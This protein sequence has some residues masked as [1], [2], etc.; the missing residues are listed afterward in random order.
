MSKILAIDAEVESGAEAVELQDAIRR[1]FERL[2]ALGTEIAG[3]QADIDRLKA[4][5]RS[6][7]ADLNAFISQEL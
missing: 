4:E 2:E 1:T 3:D 7:L 5:S 6:M